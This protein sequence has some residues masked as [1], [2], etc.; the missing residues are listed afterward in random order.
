MANPID[1]PQNFSTTLNVAGGI[2]ASQTTGIILT[3]V[4]GLPTDGGILAIDWASPI[5]TTAIEYIEYTGITA[6]ELTGVTRG[7]EGYTA[8]THN[9][10]ATI[11]GVVSRQ[12]IKRLR[13]K[14]TG[15]D[16][17]AIQ[18]PNANEIVKTTYVASAVNEL[19]VANAATANDPSIAA[20]GGDTNIGAI[21]KGKGTGKVR[22]GQ[23]TSLGVQLEADQPLLDSAG[24]ELVKVVKTASA[25]N[26]VTVANA[27]T[28]GNPQISATGDDANIQLDIIGKGTK[29]IRVQDLVPKVFAL[30]D[31]A[32]I[33][34]N[35]ALGNYA[36]VT[37]AGNRTM[38]NPTN[39]TDGQIITYELKQDATGT[40]TITWSSTAGG[41]SFGGGTAPTLS[42]AASKVDLIGFRYSAT[43][44]K[45]LYLGSQTGF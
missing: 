3:S 19:T 2:N 11:V 7:V 30:T 1:V 4:T 28:G 8:K 33:A 38:D 10:G 14:L 29:G 37:L 42:T 26:E 15:N 23:A 12:H 41:F 32:N 45:W 25:V 40:R 24:N 39:P 43:V 5:D 9:N 13:D 17:V 35:A 31:A 16:A 44:G 36:T 22:L 18:D 34:T 27:A 6:N 21:V 20:T